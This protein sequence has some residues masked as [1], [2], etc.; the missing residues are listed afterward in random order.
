MGLNISLSNRLV[1]KQ[2]GEFN[3]A[4]IQSA[5]L[6]QF[7]FGKTAISGSTVFD[8][9]TNKG[10]ARDVQLGRCFDFDGT[11]DYVACPNTLNMDLSGNTL[12]IKG[13]FIKDN[14]AS[15]ETLIAQGGATG[16]WFLYVDTSNQLRILMRQAGSGAQYR[17]FTFTFTGIITN[18]VKYDFDVTFTSTTATAIVNGVSVGTTDSGAVGVYGDATQIVSIGVR[19][20]G[21]LF[22]WNGKIWGIELY[23][24]GVLQASYKM[25]EQ[26]GTTSFD[27]SGNDRHGTI[28]NATL[29]TF[30]STQDVYSYQNEQGYSEYTYLDGVNDFVNVPLTTIPSNTNFTAG[31]FFYL[32]TDIANTNLNNYMFTKNGTFAMLL[33]HTDASLR[34]LAV[35]IAPHGYVGVG[36]VTFPRRKLFHFAFTYDGT[37]L[38]GYL[39]GVEVGT[40]TISGTLS[41][42]T[43][44]YRIGAWTDTTFLTTGMAPEVRVYGRTLSA[45]EI[46]AWKNR[47]DVSA[48]SL[49]FHL[50]DTGSP[51]W[52]DLSGNGNN[53]TANGSPVDTLVPQDDSSPTL[54]I[55]GKTL[56][57]TGRVPYNGLLKQ[58]NCVDLDGINDYMNIPMSAG[59]LLNN[60]TLKGRFRFNTFTLNGRIFSN[61]TGTLGYDW[62]AT[63][64]GT[65]N[66]RTQSTTTTT[67]TL[68]TTAT[69]YD[70]AVT[71]ASGAVKIYVDGVLAHTD[72][73]DAV[74]LSSSL[75]TS[76]GFGVTTYSNID[77]MDIG[78]HDVVLTDQEILDWSNGSNITRG[79]TCRYPVAE[80]GGVI[81]HDK[82]GNDE[83]ATLINGATWALQDVYHHNITNPVNKYMNFDAV[84]D[85]V[86]VSGLDATNGY[87]G[88]CTISAKVFVDNAIA[89]TA[90]W[91]HGTNAYRLYITG[92]TWQLNA[93]G[94]VGTVT[95]GYHTV[96]VEYNATGDAIR[97]N[98]DGADVWTGTITRGGTPTTY[99]DIGARDG[100]IVWGG[101]I[102]DFAITGSSV[103]NFAFNG[104][105]NTDADWLDTTGGGNDGV[106]NG[107]PKNRYLPSANGTTDILGFPIRNTAGGEGDSFH[108]GA[109]TL[110]DFTGGVASPEAVINSW[111]TAWTFNTA[112]TNPKFKRTITL[113]GIDHRMDRALAYS[114]ALSGSDLTKV[115]NFTA[116]RA[117]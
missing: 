25:D 10:D 34:G 77:F 28:T 73:V 1:T 68:I 91:S 23:K 14:L 80:G 49:T 13:Y 31:G 30:H 116:T 108:N 58:S 76:V 89:T 60:F 79:A 99:F 37:T 43:N 105:G 45:G 66:F 84:N 92:G 12:R 36:E 42:N 6:K 112:R 7:L 8:E 61:R 33:G 62:W 111:E 117:L 78:I 38:R 106:V 52:I 18:G 3:P 90:V 104:Y 113:N 63:T 86:R 39:D 20:N 83:H 50:E 5:S 44:P 11:N 98:L 24:N 19:N 27:S 22:F 47:E 2:K 97:F 9:S 115:E 69:W 53:G 88:A 94:N 93:G 107:S 29:S 57:Y 32:D 35:S 74:A 40:N 103:K 67:P 70:L 100:G 96:E 65:M 95:A 114:A 46:L 16:G 102:W 87:F 56:K 59:N 75:D 48:T 21:D 110:I 82:S 85:Y 54:D 72:T 81:V 51:T 64:S 17:A 71:Y 26:A 15:T 101:L 4:S 109:E 55:F 41:V